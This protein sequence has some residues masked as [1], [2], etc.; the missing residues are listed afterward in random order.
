MVRGVGRAFIFASADQ[1][2]QRPETML[3]TNDQGQPPH[4]RRNNPNRFGGERL[5]EQDSA[6]RPAFA[7]SNRTFAVCYVFSPTV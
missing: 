7:H 5:L 1:L 6:T 4:S 3:R 2:V